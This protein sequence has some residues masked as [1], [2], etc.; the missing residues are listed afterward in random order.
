MRKKKALQLLEALVE[1]QKCMGCNNSK[2][3]CDMLAKELADMIGKHVPV[4]QQEH[5]S[6]AL[7]IYEVV[8]D[9]F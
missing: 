8:R 3:L 5:Y 2:S 1:Q 7:S 9:D 4:K 6:L